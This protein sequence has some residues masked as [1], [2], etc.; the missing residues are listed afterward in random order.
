MPA[1]PITPAFRESR[2]KA[3]MAK[4]ARRDEEAARIHPGVGRITLSQ[5]R[6]MVMLHANGPMTTMEIAANLPRLRGISRS[7]MGVSRSYLRAKVLYPLLGKRLLLR[8]PMTR[9]PGFHG[10][11]YSA[12]WMVAQ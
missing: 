11:A 6:V 2:R 3:E 5:A 9:R 4:R 12:V 1:Y 8:M 10:G 7:P